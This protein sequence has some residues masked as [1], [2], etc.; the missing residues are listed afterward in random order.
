MIPKN[1]NS[2]QALLELSKFL[3]EAKKQQ[4][5]LFQ[6]MEM[7]LLQA[8]KKSAGKLIKKAPK[9]I[10]KKSVSASK[11]LKKKK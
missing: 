9:K 7:A 3:K 1:N 2:Q 5:A 4:E 11:P 8:H 10:A 6:D